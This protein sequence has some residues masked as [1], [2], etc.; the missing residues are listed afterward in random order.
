MS[1]KS[2]V[3]R[4]C[5]SVVYFVTAVSMLS[6]ADKRHGQGLPSPLMSRTPQ[7]LPEQVDQADTD[8]RNRAA[9]TT[10]EYGCF[11]PPLNSVLKPTVSVVDLQVPGKPRSEFESG[12]EALRKKKTADAEKHLRKAVQQYEKYAAAWV[13]L[14][15]LL[16]TEQKP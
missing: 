9:I 5:L 7:H 2:Y 10:N 15:Q 13:L 14:G 3:L 4:R 6:G 11:L 16:E 8:H 1:P 12:C